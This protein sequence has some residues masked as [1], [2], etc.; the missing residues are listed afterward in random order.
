MRESEI[1]L[2]VHN[3]FS[4]QQQFSVK[5]KLCLCQRGG[6]KRTHSKLPIFQFSQRS[7]EKTDMQVS[8]YL[9]ENGPTG[10]SSSL[11]SPA[12]LSC[13]CDHGEGKMI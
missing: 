12:L 6:E 13:S 11:L 1:N 8:F 7:S 5:V 10:D 3:P 9:E 4:S 2:Q